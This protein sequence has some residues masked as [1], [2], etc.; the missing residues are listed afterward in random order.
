M[1]KKDTIFGYGADE[2]VQFD[3]KDQKTWDKA[4][5]GVS[6]LYSASLDPLVE[7]HMKFS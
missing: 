2:I 3:Y 1:S 5:D 6:V 4:M 7:H